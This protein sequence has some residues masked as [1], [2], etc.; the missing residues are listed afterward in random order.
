L[1]N[2]EHYIIVNIQFSIKFDFIKLNILDI[3]TLSKAVYK[4]I[5]NLL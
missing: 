2:D 3:F 4:L 1:K 5:S